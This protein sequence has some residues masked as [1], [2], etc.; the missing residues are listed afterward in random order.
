MSTEKNELKLL[1]HLEKSP[2]NV[3]IRHLETFQ[4]GFIQA[5]SMQ[6]GLDD[7]LISKY[8]NQATKIFKALTANKVPKKFRVYVYHYPGEKRIG[9]YTTYQ[10]GFGTRCYYEIDVMA[11]NGNDAKR[12]AKEIMQQKILNGE[13]NSRK[14]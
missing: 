8:R 4:D 2:A 10:G 14:Q 3:K 11:V 5:M 13:L 1:Q 6:V 9:T 12:Q 7:Y